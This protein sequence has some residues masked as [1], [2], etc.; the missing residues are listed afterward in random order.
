MSNRGSKLW[1]IYYVKRHY[2]VNTKRLCCK[3]FHSTRI[4]PAVDA[5]WWLFFLLQSPIY[6]LWIAE[7]KSESH[8]RCCCVCD[9]DPRAW[10]LQRLITHA[11]QLLLNIDVECPTEAEFP[12]INS[13]IPRTVEHWNSLPYE[14][15]LKPTL[16]SLLL[17]PDNES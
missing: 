3:C 8:T 12:N 4:R 17:L 14:D 16:S 2:K 7:Y 6:I 9:C 1:R 5:D 11:A 13:L 10:E 15:R